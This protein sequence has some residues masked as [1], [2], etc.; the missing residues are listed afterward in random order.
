MAIAKAKNKKAAS[1]DKIPNEVIK[2]EKLIHILHKL[3]DCCFSNN[4]EGPWWQKGNT[5]TSHL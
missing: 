5:L 1:L 3:F 4:A 2:N